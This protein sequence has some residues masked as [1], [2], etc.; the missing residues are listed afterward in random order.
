MPESKGE[1][2]AEEDD[3]E[4]K[5]IVAEVCPLAWVGALETMLHS[6]SHWCT[7]QEVCS[8][9]LRFPR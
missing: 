7:S 4:D 8:L 1:S 5:S 2:S 3:P 9:F 6:L